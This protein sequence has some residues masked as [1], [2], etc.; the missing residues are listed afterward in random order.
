MDPIRVV[1]MGNDPWSVLP[2]EAIADSAL[3]LA[4]VVTRTA[5]PAGRGSEFRRTAVAEVAEDRHLPLLEVVS[6][7]D[8]GA[9]EALRGAEP[10]LL[11]VVAYGEILPPPVLQLTPLGAVNLHFSM[12]PRWRGASP[13]RRAIWEGDETTG[14]STILLDEGLDTGPILL[15]QEEEIRPEDD[16]GSL[17]ERLAA[18]GGPLLVQT[19][20][21]LAEGSVEPRPQDEASAT[22]A[23]KITTE[24]RRLDWSR[25]A[26]HLV[27]QIRALSPEPGASSVFRG[28]TLKVFSARAEGWTGEVS[29]PGAVAESGE[30]GIL[31]AA[32]IGGVRLLLVAQAGRRRMTAAEFAR[33][34][35]IAAGER[36]G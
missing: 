25:D 14:V 3:D 20:Q 5:R 17:G 8:D 32:G 22:L 27:R 30:E 9:L 6:I 12:L 7:R 15:Q 2:M 16:A 19:I 29:T 11:A 35:R 23:P 26:G 13:V 24:D 36:L 34:A 31:V 28:D 21:D 10:D 4:L 33:G 18:T 1:F